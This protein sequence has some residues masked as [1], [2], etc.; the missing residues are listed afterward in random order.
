[1]HPR[2]RVI[3]V[4]AIEVNT[5]AGAAL[6]AFVLVEAFALYQ[7]VR[8]VGEKRSIRLPLG[9]MLLWVVITLPA[10]AVVYVLS[11]AHTDVDGALITVRAMAVAYLLLA[12]GFLR[13]LASKGGHA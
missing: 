8:L 9:I 5:L 2:R 13:L 6:L 11:M 3:D 7:C 4:N 12:M 1:M 10:A